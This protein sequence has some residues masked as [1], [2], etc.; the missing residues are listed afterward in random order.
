MR[1]FRQGYELPIVTT[2]SDLQ[3]HGTAALADK[4]HSLHEQL[5]RFRLDAECEIVNLRAVALGKGAS[6][7]LPQAAMDGPSPQHALTDEHKIYFDGKF[8]ST[9]IYDRAKLQPGNRMTGPAIVTEMDSTTVI[10]PN[11]AGE[12]DRYF[13]ILI[14]P[15]A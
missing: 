8:L 4:F 9:P 3:T 1:Y 12:V 10:L 15:E 14:R 6:L 11:F 5:Y 7:S 13:N 2:L